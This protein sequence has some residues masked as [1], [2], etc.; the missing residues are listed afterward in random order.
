M[1]VEKTPEEIMEIL[2]RI[3][4]DLS[5][6]GLDRNDVARRIEAVRAASEPK[7][8]GAIPLLAKFVYDAT[9]DDKVIN[10]AAAVEVT[11]L[12][13][14]ITTAAREWS[15]S[16]EG[17]GSIFERGAPAALRQAVKALDEWEQSL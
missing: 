12:V 1:T 15:R 17:L 8:L 9:V 5:E 4:I 11:N 14:T 16:S 2:G 3:G 7:R 10:G 6:F 13:L